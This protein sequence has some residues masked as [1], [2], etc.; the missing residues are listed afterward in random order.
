MPNRNER[1][2][3]YELVWSDTLK[4]AGMSLFLALGIRTFA[5]GAYFIPSG[6]MKPTIQIDD[7][8]IVNKLSYDFVNPQRG[9]IVVFNPPDAVLKEEK[10]NSDPF[11][12]R[13]IGL[14]GDKVEV[15]NGHVYVNDCLLQESYIAAKPDYAYGPVR[16]PID[17]YL[18][19]GDNRN[20]SYDGHYWGFIPR[21]RI[22]GKAIYRFW[23]LDRM[24]QLT[25]RP[26]YVCSQFRHG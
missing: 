8:L 13:V 23:P 6:S 12:K 15:K 11:I 3:R 19:L 7:R 24:G 16:I 21:D 26:I 9:D 25:Q 14:P 20:N 18:M 4:F 2:P 1:P 22:I 5:A 17:S 10:V